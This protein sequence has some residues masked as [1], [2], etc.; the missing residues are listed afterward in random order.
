MA[1]P[2]G[3]ESLDEAIA[4]TVEGLDY[5]MSHG[6][7]PRFT[8]WCPEPT[9]PLGRDNPGGAPLISMYACWASTATRSR[10][11]GWNPARV[12]RAGG[13]PSGLLRQL[14]H[15]RAVRISV[16]EAREL[17][18]RGNDDELQR[19]AGQVRARYHEPDRAMDMVMR[20]INYTQTSA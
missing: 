11:T 6:V 15:G 16:D 12:R 7:T 5:F 4:S 1:R 17:W 3:F 18:L 10:A 13:R 20:I 14:L 2:F 9:T 19:L 8:T